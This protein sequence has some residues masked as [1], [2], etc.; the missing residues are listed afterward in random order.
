MSNNTCPLCNGK[1][2]K[3]GYLCREHSIELLKTIKEGLK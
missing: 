1:I 3:T 2:T